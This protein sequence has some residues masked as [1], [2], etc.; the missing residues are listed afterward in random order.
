MSDNRYEPGRVEVA[1][2]DGLSIVKLLGEH[3]LSTQPLIA[4]KLAALIESGTPLVFDLS[5]ATFMDSSVVQAVVTAQAELAKRG[6]SIALVV[7]D[8][9]ATA[10]S[11]LIEMVGLAGIPIVRSRDEAKS[12]LLPSGGPAT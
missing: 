8:D 7:P 5:D 6:V 10:I 12:K 11:R 4:A 9:A 3:D 1:T 2:E